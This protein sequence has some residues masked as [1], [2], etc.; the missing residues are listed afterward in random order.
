MHSEHRR[1]VLGPK[2]QQQVAE[3]SEADEKQYQQVG[4]RGSWLIHG[5]MI[6]AV[7]GRPRPV[8]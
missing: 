1:Q 8:M 4:A 2:C 3:S 7:R 6:A 5:L